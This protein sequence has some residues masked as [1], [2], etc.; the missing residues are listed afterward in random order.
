MKK[1][2]RLE[3]KKKKAKR[4]QSIHTERASKCRLNIISS[5]GRDFLAIHMEYGIKLIQYSTLR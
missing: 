1:N 3:E 2:S 5:A 4:C